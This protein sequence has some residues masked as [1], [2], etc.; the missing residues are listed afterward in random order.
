MVLWDLEEGSGDSCR[1]GADAFGECDFPVRPCVGCAVLF[2]F[3]LYDANLPRLSIPASNEP[4]GCLKPTKGWLV[5]ISISL[6]DVRLMEEKS[7][8]VMEEV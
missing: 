7:D 5:D 2:D 4:S 1:D 8:T 6:E 3:I